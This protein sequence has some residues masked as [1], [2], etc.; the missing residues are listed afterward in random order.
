[1]EE[2][3]TDFGKKKNSQNEKNLRLPTEEWLA[4]LKKWQTS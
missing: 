2:N 1:M 3:Q 4:N